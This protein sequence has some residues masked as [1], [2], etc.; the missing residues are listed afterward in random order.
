MAVGLCDG[1]VLCDNGVVM[2]DGQEI[3]EAETR[4]AW[5]DEDLRRAG[6]S[7]ADEGLEGAVRE[8]PVAL[9][10]GMGRADYVLF[11]GDGLP[12][13]V[14]EAKR[15]CVDRQ[16]GQTQ[17]GLYADGLERRFGRRP[18]VFL[19]N[20]AE[21]TFWDDRSGSPRRVSGIFARED[22]ERLMDSRERRATLHN[23]RVDE[24][25][26]NRPY[27]L[28]AI[29]AICEGLELGRRRHL[30]VMATGTGKTRTA[31]SLVDVLSRGGWVK[32]VLF[33]ADRLALVR[34]AKEAFKQH[35]PEL[36]L[37][38]LCEGEEPLGARVVFATYPT[39]LNALDAAEGARF[40][41]AHFDLIVVD[42]AHRSIFK[43]YRAIFAY[44]DAIL[45]GL[46][47]TPKVEVDRNTYDFFGM[48]DGEPTFAY[49][50]ET[51]EGRDKVLVPYHLMEVKTERLDRGIVYD[52]LSERDKERYDE[53]WGDEPPPAVVEPEQINHFIF[54]ADTV[55]LVLQD[56]M[57]RGIK[58][59]GGE[60]LGKTII[61]A[62]NA[63][64]ARFIEERF[65]AL[66]PYY[67]GSFAR[68]IVC[69]DRFAQTLIEHF[70]DP[71]RV[72]QI[73]ISVD[74]MDTGIDVPE[75]VNLVFFKRVY[76]KAKFWQMLGR[77][78]RLCPGLACQDLVDGAY[79]GKRRFFLFDYCDNCAFF[80]LNKDGEEGQAAQSLSETLFARRVA[81]IALF[82]GAE[83][84]A[85]TYR[86]WRER[87]VAVCH[88]QVAA[89]NREL[90]SVRL[91]A[92]AV[93]RFRNWQAYVCLSEK[94]VATLCE[95]IAPLVRDPESDEAAK[96]FDALIYGLTLAWA[97]SSPA[98]SQARRRVCAIAE[99]LMRKTSIPQVAA[100]LETLRR[101][102]EDAFWEQ[103]DPSA[104]EALRLE[105]RELAR[106]L[107][108]GE[109]RIV[110]T[111]VAD[112]V[113]RVA[114]GGEL[115][116]GDDFVSYHDRV[117][118]Y[119]RDHAD[120]APIYKLTHN[121]PLTKAD[122][123]ALEHILF[124][125]LG[126]KADYASSFSDMPLG[127]MVRRVAH[128]DREA[129]SQAFAA[130][131]NTHALNQAQIAF[132]QRIIT[133]VTLHGAVED[134]GIFV[135]P[136][137]DRPAHFTVLFE[138]SE[139]RAIGAILQSLRANALE[140]QAGV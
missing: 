129:V 95:E 10:A 106:F 99:T 74:M 20:G 132:V 35:L 46:T 45:V 39:L 53:D 97:E 68:S 70:R 136:P 71:G 75:C 28:E 55:D 123:E 36:A 24:R 3:T 25:I 51:A 90:V 59:D 126:T 49:E 109:R 76:S 122:F 127:L 9:P 118:R 27:Q 108:Q 61:F 124:H 62:Q 50:Y 19:T 23:L 40:S 86:A 83:Y 93:E 82:Q 78:T 85:D 17:A 37:C 116:Q 52:D 69:E 100:R 131:I 77:G 2:S 4:A 107:E 102:R 1:V 21:T 15:W 13:A 84:G 98:V 42:E 117:E 41:V 22:L 7:L 66:Y 80:R 94:D 31:V 64:H 30:L 111:D 88:G 65:N 115:P 105:L 92:R 135:R 34:Q 89:L 43:K 79:A 54:N 121:L 113:L 11:G 14:V 18:M 103:A 26:T 119:L 44:L 12:L 81:L 73:A 48:K 16:A 112:R 6:W 47:A 91:H 67:R 33:L 96:R 140:P 120:D 5:I 133:Y 104:F 8:F 60:K 130:F 38:N 29:R 128:M 58:V 63:R 137:F 56:V 72:P 125:V 57:E 114:E 139:G 87:L 138:E 134:F 101:V 110:F 32:N